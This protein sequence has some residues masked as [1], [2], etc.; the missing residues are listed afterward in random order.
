MSTAAATDDKPPG[1]F[2]AL[3]ERFADGRVR[4]LLFAGLGGLAMLFVVLFERGA[5]VGGVMILVLGA[6][7]LVLGWRGSPT[8]VVLILLYFLVFPYGL[9]PWEEDPFELQEGTFRVADL[10]LAAAL[11]VYLSAHYRLLGLTSL[12]IPPEPAGFGHKPT[13]RKRP[14]DLVRKGELPRLFYL[15]AAVVVLGQIVWSIVINLEVDVL[16]DFPLR[17]AEGPVWRRDGGDMSPWRTRLTVVVGLIF[18]GTLLARLVF[19]YWRLRT[20]TPAEGAMLLTDAGW[21]ETK[22]ERVRVES[23]R[24]WGVKHV[25]DRVRAGFGKRGKR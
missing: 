4:A 6:A 12:A 1:R 22:R 3:V 20:M 23:W 7:G 5:D 18:F 24:M 19:G 2:D 10:M 9:P 11:V 25:A 8:F 15:A 13:Q 17:T 14:A 16:A 21:N